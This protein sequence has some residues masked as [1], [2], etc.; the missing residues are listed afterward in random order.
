MKER[1]AKRKPVTLPIY[2]LNEASEPI[3]SVNSDNISC[4]GVFIAADLPFK[5]DT[6]VLIRFTLPS[7]DNTIDVSASVIRIQKQKRGPGRKKDIKEGL[8]LRFVGLPPTD[9][10]QIETFVNS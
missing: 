5:A 1:L 9:Y 3:F 6:K 10:A 7:T 2:F 4:S 8:G